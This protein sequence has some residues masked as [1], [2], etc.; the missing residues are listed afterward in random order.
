MAIL[1]VGIPS[2]FLLMLP[3]VATMIVLA[4]VIG[5]G[6]TPAADGVPYEKE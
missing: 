3:Y 1:N 5:R 4:G 2:E 6:H